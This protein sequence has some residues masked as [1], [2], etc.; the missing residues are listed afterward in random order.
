MRYRISRSASKRKFRVTSGNTR[1]INIFP[2]VMRGG[3]RL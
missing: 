2:Q 1:A 3:F